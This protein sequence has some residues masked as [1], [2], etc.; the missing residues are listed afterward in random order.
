MIKTKFNL[1]IQ[2]Y[3]LIFVLLANFLF[4]YIQSYY[5]F[6][7]KI[8]KPDFEKL[9]KELP[10]QSQEEVYLS[11]INLVTLY[12]LVPQGN[13]K[14]YE[15][16]FKV[17]EKCSFPSDNSCISDYNNNIFSNFGHNNIN[18][19]NII[20]TITNNTMSKDKCTD[21]KIGLAMPGY[22]GKERCISLVKEIKNN[23]LHTNSRSYSFQ[24]YDKKKQ[25]EK[26]FDGEL[27]IG[28][29]PH[30]VNGSGYNKSDFF[31]I[32]NYVNDYYYP[33][34]GVETEKD[35]D[36]KYINFSM[37]F[38]KI[39]YYINNSV[40]PD[41]IKYIG[42]EQ[43][44]E[45][46]IDFEIGL[47]KCPF[48]HYILT[49]KNF[50]GKYLDDNSCKEI[51]LWGG[52]YGI[53]CDKKKINSKELYKNFNTLYFY[54][55]NFN[56]T[57]TLTSKEVFFEKNN[58]IY[59]TLISKN[60]ALSIWRF[61]HIFLKKYFLT[62]DLEKK[63]IGFYIT[64]RE[65]EKESGKVD[66]NNGEHDDKKRIISIGYLILILEYFY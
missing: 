18:I 61:G 15:L 21:I 25:K 20:N 54:N 55:I 19:S 57:F 36:G 33:A 66:P 8:L 47:I 38:S 31:T 34:E 16:I 41:N 52:Y 11:Y 40:S 24:F 56:Y 49:K 12:T 51:I 3:F 14:I 4:N 44:N 23:D 7:F 42:S 43:S 60:D 6:P 62:F 1:I 32:Y 17:S 5:I 26:N 46:S 63:A 22:S 64:D 2:K 29:E 65:R 53:I 35:W 27:L 48:G 45:G 10:N 59:F 58:K 13:S 9:T 30:G 39:Y 37:S 28:T 50:F